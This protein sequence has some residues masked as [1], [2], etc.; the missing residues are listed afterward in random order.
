M[1]KPTIAIV[2]DSFLPRWDGLARAIIELIP[3]MTHA[4]NFELIAPRYAGERPQFHGVRYHLF[5]M[6][7]WVRIEGAGLPLVSKRFMQRALAHVDLV[8]THSIGP[9]GNT[10]VSIAHSEAVPIV[11]MIHSIEWEIYA[12]NLPIGQAHFRNFWLKTCRQRYH[13]AQQ[14]VTPSQATKEILEAHGFSS[15]ISV[16]PLGIDTNRFR[17]RPAS[18]RN[19]TREALN[20]P[21]DA[22]LFGYLGRFGAEKNLQVLIDAFTQLSHP[23]TH[24]LMVGGN[25]SVLRH[26]KE[27]RRISW[28][29]S[30]MTPED[31]YPAM[32]AYVLPSLSECAPLAIREAMA[33]GVIPLSTPVGNVPTYL[34]PDIG[35]LFAPNSVA[36]LKRKML[37]LL[38]DPN[39]HEPRKRKARKLVMDRFNW[40]ASSDR[41]IAIFDKILQRRTN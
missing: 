28:I 6:L 33:C 7:P 17:P 1:T 4:Y 22:F 39:S 27:D 3:R 10:A 13:K 9:L 14:I 36:D 12:Q 32:D 30:T 23:K 16:T 41:I 35:T 26:D 19:R 34:T 40:A 37:E 38:N 15:P 24:L 8:W 5:P 21:E 18:E 20:I 2:A 29:P 11:S 25:R 31:F